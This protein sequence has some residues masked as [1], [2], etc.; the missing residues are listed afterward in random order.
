MAARGGSARALLFPSFDGGRYKV[1]KVV[2]GHPGANHGLSCPW[3][4][5]PGVLLIK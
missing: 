2:E 4:W 5:A 3:Q 1:Y